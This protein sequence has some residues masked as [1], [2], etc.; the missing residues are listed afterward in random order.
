MIQHFFADRE[1]VLARRRKFETKEA[2]KPANKVIS[3][4]SS[5]VEPG[6]DPEPESGAKKVVPAKVRRMTSDD[7]TDAISLSVV[8]TLV[9]R[10]KVASDNKALRFA[11]KFWKC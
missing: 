11:N 6:P 10:P 4:K 2:V 3:L 5:S 9:G 7:P 8:D 1:R